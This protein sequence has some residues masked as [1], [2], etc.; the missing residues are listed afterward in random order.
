MHACN[1]MHLGYLASMLDKPSKIQLQRNTLSKS[2]SQQEFV[3]QVIQLQC[4]NT[5]SKLFSFNATTCLVLEVQR[6]AQVS[7]HHHHS[8]VEVKLLEG[9]V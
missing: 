8:S 2:V 1:V 6:G 4:R 7:C 3:F 5:S 9:S